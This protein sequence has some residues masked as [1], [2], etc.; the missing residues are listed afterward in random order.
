MSVMNHQTKKTGL[1]MRVLAFFLLSFAVLSV[2]AQ[3]PPNIGFEQNNFT[4]WNGFTGSHNGTLPVN[5]PTAGIVAGRHT[6]T[7]GGFDGTIPSIPQVCPL[8]GF[9]ARSVRLGNSSTGAQAERLTTTFTVTPNTSALLFAFAVI[10]EDPGHSSNQQPRFELNIT[11]PNQQNTPCGNYVYVA[12]NNLPGFL[13]QGGVR[14]RPW[15]Q[16]S[17]NLIPF[18]GQAVTV[19][20][21]TADCSA[22]GHFGFAYFDMTCDIFQVI[23]RYCPGDQDA[24]LTAPSGFTSYQWSPT[25]QTTQSILVQNPVNNSVY[26]VTMIPLGGNPGCSV[27]IRDTIRLMGANTSVINNTCNGAMAGSATIAVTGGTPFYNYTWST[28]PVQ[29]TATAT[30]LAAGTY[31]ARITDAAQCTVNVSV[32]LVDPPPI[33]NTRSSTP[34]SCYGGSNGTATVNMIGGSPPYIYS[35]NSTPVQNT[36]TATGLGA[37]TW[38]VSVTDQGGCTNQLPVTVSEPMQLVATVTSTNVLCNGAATG[39]GL[40]VASGGVGN[41]GYSWNTNPVQNNPNAT[42]LT[43]GTYIATVTDG[44]NCTVTNTIIV[45]QPPAM[46]ATTTTTPVSCFGGS[47]GTAEVMANGGVG[48][49]SYSWNTVPAQLTPIAVGLGAQTYTVTVTDGNGCV[50]NRTAAPTEPTQLQ[51]SPTFTPVSCFAGADGSVSVTAQDGTPGYSYSWNTNPIQVSAQVNGLRAGTYSVTVTDA[52][53]CSRTGSVVVTEPTLLTVT[54]SVTPVSC[55]GGLDG[56]ATAQGNGGTTPYAYLWTTS[57]NQ[58]TATAVGLS[59]G[60]YQ[61]TV[62]DAN[63]CTATAI[64]TI[65]EPTPVTLTTTHT[66]ALCFGSSDG[67][68]SAQGFGGTPGYTYSWNTAPIQNTQTATGLVIGTYQVTVTD[69]NNCTAVGEAVIAQPTQLNG[70]TTYTPA[71]CFG[72]ADGTASA[73]AF[74][75]TPGYTYSWNT[76]PVQNTQTAVGL[77]AGNY[78]VTITDSHNC[79]IQRNVVITQPTQVM[80]NT[81]YT[82]TLCNG[83]SDG[84]ATVLPSGGT[85]GYT[86]TWS[87]APIQQNQT[88]VGLRA[89][90]YTVN[91][92]DF[93]NCPAQT[94]VVVTEP[95]QLDAQITVQNVRCFGETNGALT[96]QGINGVGPYMYAWQTDPPQNLP[97]ASNLAKGVYTVRITDMNG[98]FITRTGTV[99]E[100][101]LLQ[102]QAFAE[103]PTCWQGNDGKVWV[104]T[105]GGTQPYFYRWN[106]N[107]SLNQATLNSVHYGWHWAMT[108]DNNGCARKDSIYVTQPDPIPKARVVNDTVCPGESAYLKAFSQIPGHKV[109]WFMDNGESLAFYEGNTHRTQAIHGQKIF[110]V[111]TEDEKGC[112]S[113]K[114]PVFALV[115]PQPIANFEVDKPKWE[116]PDAIFNFTDKTKAVAGVASYTWEFGDGEVSHLKDPVHQYN[117]VGYYNVKLTVIDSNGCKSENEKLNFVEVELLVGVVPP[118]AFSPN[119]DGANDYFYIESSKIRSWQIKIFDRWGNQ[120]YESADLLFRWNG[121]QAGVPLPEGTYVYYLDGIAMDGNKVARSGSILLIR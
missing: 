3:C 54:Q 34:V 32:T 24:I 49:F 89:G 67:T 2:G 86:Y 63:N 102:G 17:I 39:T 94:Q 98:C 5:T 82:P 97:T 31:S 10:M 70:V 50:L 18:I 109:Y 74:Q 83:S 99:T 95:V 85:P 112:Q 116:L 111:R 101:A 51:I 25:G 44:N 38:T 48:N 30:G 79:S 68:V 64:S 8:P 15:A 36:A 33:A 117:E 1:G 91:V 103:S 19:N 118:N 60:T 59:L 22:S 28:S 75:G 11:L 110:F 9:G 107:Y 4:G 106:N 108:I 12:S 87:T 26:T 53:N 119:G 42:N 45:D 37:G 71:L 78:T 69:L 21:L 47:N 115:H 56:T 73:E 93:Q 14:Y 88:A 29:T 62:T 13:T 43:A 7:T 61:V 120:V 16:Q 81:T 23:R 58:A 96:A 65:T 52:N 20:I 100:P 84:S 72:A 77:A 66:D 41:Y 6:V 105:T 104:T 113:P 76:A 57:P 80:L 114:V 27:T 40:V 90:T 92:R 46:T 121:T 55:F 35:W